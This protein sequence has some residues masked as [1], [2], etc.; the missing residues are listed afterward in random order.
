MVN[1]NLLS[2]ILENIL[3]SDTDDDEPRPK[4]GGKK[5]KSKNREKVDDTE[6]QFAQAEHTDSEDGKY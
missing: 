1:F 5:G 2:L 4:K 3:S 6:I